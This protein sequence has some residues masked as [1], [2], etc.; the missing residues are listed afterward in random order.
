MTDYFLKITLQSP[1]SS[2]VGLGRVGL[3]DR[4]V[5]YD[6]LGL[7]IL[8][9]RRLKGLW[10]EAYSN[11]Y[12]AWRLCGKEAM[13]VDEIFGKP[14]QKSGDSGISIHIANA[15]LQE[16]SFLNPWLRHLQHPD[17]GTQE[18]KLYLEDVLQH[19]ATVREQTA[20]DRRTGSAAENTLRLTRTLK[21]DLVFHAH[22]YFG[23]PNQ[24]VS[25]TPE[26]IDALAIG[27]AALQQMGT[28][29][30]RGIGQVSCR[31]FG[32]DTTGR[33]CDLTEEALKRLLCPIVVQ[34]VTQ[35]PRKSVRPQPA[36]LK[37]KTPTHVLRYR[38]T[39][40][41]P[42]VIRVADGDPN[43]VV[44]RQDI[45]GSHILGVVAWH[46]LRQPNHLPQDPDFCHAFLDGGLRFL[47]A[48]P[49]AA[50]NQQRLIPIPH[51]IRKFKDDDTLID[52]MEELP[53]ERATRRIER[54]YACI[55][56]NLN[57]QAVKTER[58]YHHARAGENAGGRSIGRA[59]GNEVEDGGTF[60][61]YEALK[62][63]QSFQGAVLGSEQDLKKLKAWLA[64]VNTIRLGR[65]RSAQ[66]GEAKFEW[67]DP[68]N[69]PARLGRVC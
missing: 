23:P 42:V 55:A 41:E 20:I 60:F 44:T 29:R 12:D 51:S 65:S 27:A 33:R 69:P 21:I 2:A 18:Q 10:R 57:T 4:D 52:F 31:L 38:L 59:L 13:S 63:D 34:K 19:F 67:I 25:P 45:P 35:P 32:P 66:Y 22:I 47:T 43:T 26:F 54:H 5:V 68:S 1:L 8:P 14:G 24:K 17:P 7:P 28:G 9:G 48:Y 62:A 56:D 46:Y 40:T 50:D 49:E 6:D 58:N 3:V 64:G 16:E 39:L 37:H 30:T 11:I 61:Q 53:G 15:K 36:R